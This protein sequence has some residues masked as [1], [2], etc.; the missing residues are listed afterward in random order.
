LLLPHRTHTATPCAL[1]TNLNAIVSE[2]QQGNEAALVGQV[3]EQFRMNMHE[4]DE[5]KVRSKSSL[6]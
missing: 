4:T 6:G 1:L 5:A 3:R 2:L